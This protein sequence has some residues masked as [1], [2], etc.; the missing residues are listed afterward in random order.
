MGRR[1]TGASIKRFEDQKLLLGKTSYV[2]D[3]TPK[4]TAYVS[5][6]RSPYPHA[7]IKSISFQETRGVLAA[8][9]GRD[10]ATAVKP[11]PVFVC[12]RG[13]RT[14]KIFPLAV[15]KA[16]YVG[17]AVAAIV[18]PSKYSAKDSSDLVSIDY[19]LLPPVTDAQ[20]AIEEGAPR[21]F[22]D[23]PDNVAYSTRLEA[24][25][26]EK[27]FNEADLVISEKFKIQ[28]QYGAPIEPRG[29]VAS[30]E[31]GTSYL[32]VWSSTQWPH[33]L[34]TVLSET[35]SV[36]ENKIRVIAPDV[37][38]G[39][40]SKQDIYPEE[41]LVPYLALKLGRPVKWVA[42]RSEDIVATSHAREQLHMVEAAVRKDGTIVGLKDRILADIGAFHVMSI[43]PQ[44]VTIATITGPYRIQNC[45]VEL[46]CVVT[47]KTPAGAYRGFGQPKSTFVIERL[48]DIIA[49]ETGLDPAE[50][51]LRNF[52]RSNEFPYT[53]PFGLT[54]DSGRYDECLNQCL[55]L[56][57][58]ERFRT[59]QKELTKSGRKIGLGIS[60]Y[61]ETGGLGP[62][63]LFR[64]R[65]IRYY[66]GHE[67]CIVKINPSG[68]I[69]VLSGLSPQGQGTATTIAQ[70]C[71][72]ELGVDIEDVTV[73][74]GDTQMVPYGFGTWGSRGAA[75]GC[76][77]LLM[78]ARKL[79]EK[80][81]RIV[82]HHFG[83]EAD[84]IEFHEGVFSVK[85]RSEQAMKIG[86][87]SKLAYTARDL[88]DGMEPGLEAV[89]FYDPQ[90]IT[91]SYAAHIAAVE[92]DSESG[93]VNIL[94]YVIVHDAGTVI[95]PMLVE[96]QV[97]G[98]VAQGLAGALFEELV[99]D[100]SG[101][102]LTPTL[103]DYLIPTSMDLPSM[104]IAHMETPSP[105][106]PLG[107][108]GIGE[109]GAIAPP[110]A[111]AN[112]VADALGPKGRSVTETPLSSEKLWDLLRG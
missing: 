49:H 48:L 29:V 79:K 60:F 109:G 69:V 5:L 93:K 2:D 1:Y 106:N 103:I 75:L 7:L 81:T 77:S 20:H 61:V 63:R 24:G 13:A 108:K 54:Y 35:L 17:H 51:R 11:I 64:G 59:R 82:A 112:A 73:I 58:Y 25:D 43:G 95:N 94:E 100:G 97:H 18:T 10:I 86:D 6:V 22:D 90:E 15:D 9:S 83:V 45:R 56:I 68:K 104:S 107:I 55:K 44:Q 65:G 12:P 57:N 34:R 62:S 41:V 50:V 31:Q 14:R 89:S 72:D 36:P 4:G 21:L 98:G 87:V 39:F 23:W 80:M 42:T 105:F 78:S 33:V 52:I 46:S 19:E 26:V 91:A 27:A 3:V 30:Y 8:V 28:R 70:V 37:G 16:L 67:S 38:G 71:A 88:P 84:R 74:H 47:N 40:G 76:A 32:T 99:Y 102:I 96:G 53:T 111:I 110:A 85:D 66:G 101:N 92:V